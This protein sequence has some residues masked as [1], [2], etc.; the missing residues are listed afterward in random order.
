V[1]ALHKNMEQ[2]SSLMWHSV[3]SLFLTS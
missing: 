2:L 1:S 3:I